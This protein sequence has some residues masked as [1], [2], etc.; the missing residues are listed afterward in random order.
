MPSRCESVGGGGERNVPRGSW[1]SA[2]ATM[3]EICTYIHYEIT[4]FLCVVS[5]KTPLQNLAQ[6][7]TQLTGEKDTVSIPLLHI[8]GSLLL[9]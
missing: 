2:S 9:R 6:A 5:D 8:F 1:G 4:F 3:R 7:A